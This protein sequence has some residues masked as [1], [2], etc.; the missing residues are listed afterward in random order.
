LMSGRAG[1]RIF[2]DEVVE[3]PKQSLEDFEGVM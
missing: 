1:E 3:A 2:A